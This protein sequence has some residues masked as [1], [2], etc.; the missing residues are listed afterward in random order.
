MIGLWYGLK[1]LIGLFTIL[2]EDLLED[3]DV[4]L[5][6]LTDTYRFFNFNQTAVMFTQITDIRI[7][8]PISTII[9]RAM[10]VGKFKFSLPKLVHSTLTIHI[11]KLIK[12]FLTN[13]TV[14]EI[15]IIL[16]RYL[17]MYLLYI[18]KNL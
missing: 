11:R 3:E 16:G 14:A 6:L 17:C 15:A 7:Y 12:I 8:S 18:Y 4:S 9:Y 2:A 13:R 10:K 5:I 1:T